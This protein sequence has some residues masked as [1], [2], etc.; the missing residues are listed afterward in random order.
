LVYDPFLHDSFLNQNLALKAAVFLSDLVGK[1]A[2]PSIMLKYIQ[3]Y[4]IEANTSH[5]AA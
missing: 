5:R 3:I 2:V 1:G 4:S